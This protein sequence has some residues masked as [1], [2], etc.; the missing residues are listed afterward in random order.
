MDFTFISFILDPLIA[1]LAGKYGIVL[2]IISVMGTARLVFKPFVLFLQAVT[3]ATPSPKDNEL[4]AKFM[5]SK[6]YTVIQFLLD[7]VASIKLPPS[8]PKQ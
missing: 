2:Q 6:A 3:T 8:A 4:L 7:Y 5:G 1:S